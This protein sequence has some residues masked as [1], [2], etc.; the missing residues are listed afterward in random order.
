M[1]K[2]VLIFIPA[3]LFSLAVSAQSVANY[4]AVRTTGITY[5]SIAAFGTIVPSW[6]GQFV[7]QNDDNRSNPVALGF[8]F[9]YCGT[10]YTHCNISI[11]GFIDFSSTPY[12]GNAPVS[13]DPN[14]TGSCLCGGFYSYREQ[15]STLWQSPTC[16]TGS[17]PTSYE[18]TYWALAA[19]YCDLWPANGN[20]ALAYSIRYAT[21]GAAPYR[22]FTVEYANMDDWSSPL[23]SDYN[24]QIKVYETTGVIEYVYGTMTPAVGSPTPYSCGINQRI[25]T[26]PPAA[27][28][29]LAQQGTNSNTFN[30]T[31]PALSTAVPTPNSQITFT[32]VCPLNPGS[33][34]TFSAIGNTTMTLNWTDWAANEIGY[35]IY[36]STDGVNYYFMSQTAANATSY[37]A[38]NLTSPTYWWKVYAVTEGC[39]STPITGTQAT[40]AGG[41]FFTV[42]SGNWTNPAIWNAMAVPTTGD[43]ATISNGHTVTIDANNQGCF[44]LTVN[45][46]GAASLLILGNAA[47]NYTFNIL[48][49]LT[50]NTNGTFRPN[51]TVNATHT[52]NLTGNI[53]NNGSITM[54]PVANRI[55]NF[56]FSRN[57]N[58]T[59]SGTAGAGLND[60]NLITLNMGASV[61]NTCEVTSSNFSAPSN[62][63]ALSN[64]TFKY[65]VPVNVQNIDIFTSI[66]T[67]PY[68]A[69]LWMNAPNSTMYAHSTLN[70]QGAITC[71]AGILHVGDAADEMLQSDGALLTVSG[72]IVTVA[73]RLDRPSY[74]AVTHVS[75][76]GGELVLARFSSTSTT[77]HPFHVD[78]IGSSLNWTGGI[79]RLTREGGTGAQ[80]LGYKNSGCLLNYNITGGILR[81]GDGAS[82]AG[83]TME[84]NSNI[85]I[86]NLL[87]NSTN[88]PTAKIDTFNLVVKGNITINTGGTLNTNNKDIYVAGNWTNDGTFQQQ[89]RRVFFNGTSA[90][91]QSLGGTTVTTF[92]DLHI[93]NTG[94]G[95][96]TLNVSPTV[97]DSLAMTNGK[98]LLNGQTIN[99]TSDNLSSITRTNGWIVSENTGNLSKVA[100]TING[101]LGSRTIPY[102]TTGGVY[103]PFT[104]N[105][106]AGSGGIL[107]TSTYGTP[108][109]NLPWPTAP[110]AVLNLNSTTGLLPDNRDATVNRF[111][112][113]DHTGV[114]PTATLTFSYDPA[115]ELPIAPYNLPADQRAQ[116][117]ESST[118]KWQ[119][120]LGGQTTTANSVTVPG[121]TT[122]SPWALASNLSP[123]PIELTHFNATC[124]NG[125]ML[126]EW[127]TGSETNNDFYTL[128]RTSDGVNFEI[129]AI[130]DG[131]GTTSQMSF[132]HFTDETPL[133]G[134]SYYRLKQTDENQTETWSDLIAANCE[135]SGDLGITVLPNPSTGTNLVIQVRTESETPVI[136]SIVNNLGQKIL[137]EQVVTDKNGVVFLNVELPE[138]TSAG[139]Y[140]VNAVSATHQYSSKL[141]IRK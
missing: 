26:N 69:G 93:N 116:R 66:A 40:V 24:F 133:P 103:I 44:D 136:V 51:N 130:I 131:A 64:G 81:I 53:V 71:S 3:L 55:A 30:N 122:F 5:S 105:M 68:T 62:F 94:T 20:Q 117:Y 43:N 86:F 32:P 92:H 52:I 75:V 141:V 38:T 12:N 138:E 125:A 47:S 118:N 14:T 88:S 61:S 98:L 100:W 79:I 135:S 70:F 120:A 41:V 119:P 39:I 124:V 36:Y 29:L 128:E 104:F 35:A 4:T 58:Q 77:K 126:I 139:V 67:I 106:T 57:G 112:Q 95:G 17:P 91:T 60:Y 74:V 78:V 23:L 8:D 73:G 16:G 37:V 137:S 115:T 76:T 102:G 96:V 42:A 80:D 48:G 114:T 1:K 10:R 83:Q 97:Q 72:G 9:W 101:I 111:W 65:S 99:V 18:G 22:C 31:I 7:N 132:Y 129:V 6:R 15:G 140:L 11:N 107:T 108:A 110:T 56:V 87:V 28:E 46:G 85:P 63:L 121:V 109:T 2:S 59:I 134:I 25:F 34:L 113:I 45:T 19:M 49:N 13:G 54:R 84:I 21:T 82:P 33:V 127:V 123:L 90:T 27:S 50:V 89:L